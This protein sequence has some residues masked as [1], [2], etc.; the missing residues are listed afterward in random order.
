[1]KTIYKLCFLILA[2]SFNLKAQELLTV[3]DA[4]KIGLEKNYSILI[5][6]NSQEIAK[7]QNNF[8]NAG[9]QSNRRI[10]QCQLDY[11]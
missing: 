3:E 2:I 10:S 6:K 9:I 8:G 5:V 11:F 7:A 1:M 4:I